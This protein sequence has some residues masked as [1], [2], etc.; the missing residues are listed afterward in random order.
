M[1]LADAM[2]PEFDQEMKATRAVLE[3]VPQARLDFRPHSKSSTLLEL[4][5][6]VAELP[7]WITRSFVGTEL[8][9][10]PPGGEPLPPAQCNTAAEILQLFDRGAKQA[11][12]TLAAARDADLP[13]VWTLKAGG[14]K[15]VAM[16]RAGMVRSFVLNHLIHHRGQLTVYLRLCDVP[17]PWVYGPTAD[18]PHTLT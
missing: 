2:L 16:P 5:T 3:V 1:T 9:V 8:D 18:K 17:L 13:V 11:R 10:A 4:A 14:R 7:Q 6:H 15:V 12:A